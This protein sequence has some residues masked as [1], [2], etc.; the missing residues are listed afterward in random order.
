MTEYGMEWVALLVSVVIQD[1]E[2][3]CRSYCDG[4]DG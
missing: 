4:H 1:D 2:K 3:N